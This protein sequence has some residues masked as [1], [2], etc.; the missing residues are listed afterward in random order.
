MGHSI[1]LRRLWRSV[2]RH[3]DRYMKFRKALK[4][5][6]FANPVLQLAHSKARGVNDDPIR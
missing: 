1:W 3:F 5:V 2:P 4:N 6:R